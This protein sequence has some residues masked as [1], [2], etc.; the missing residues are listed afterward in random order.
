M[1]ECWRKI[2][3]I[4]NGC[5]RSRVARSPSGRVEVDA[6][7]E[8]GEVGGGHLD[9][10]GVGVGDAEGAAFQSFGPDGEAVAIPIQDLDAI[11]PFIEEDEEVS[12][13]RIELEGTGSQRGEAVK[14]LAHVGRFFGEINSDGRAQSEHRRSSTVS[15][16]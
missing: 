6:G 15:M 16:S 4:F 8:C 9:A 3:R 10:G 11:A 7:Q 1:F 5:A 13:E 2:L 14:T 12:R